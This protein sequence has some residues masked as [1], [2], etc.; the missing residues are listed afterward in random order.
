MG[1][2]RIVNARRINTAMAAL[3]LSHDF[4]NIRSSMSRFI[5]AVSYRRL[6]AGLCTGPI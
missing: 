4:G 3:L 5:D 6:G 1:S 2:V